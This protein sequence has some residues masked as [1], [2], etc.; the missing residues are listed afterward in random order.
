MMAMDHMTSNVR[1]ESGKPMIVANCSGFF[2]D[3]LS[4]AREMVEGGPIDILTGDYLAELTMLILWKSKESGRGRG[5]VH[6]FLKQMEEVLG[7]CLDRGIRVVANA[8][9]LNPAG[10]AE[11]LRSL[12]GRLGLAPQIA[13]VEGDDLLARLPELLDE[14]HELRHMDTGQLLSEL[15]AN[16]ITANA[17]LGAWGIADALEGGADIVVCPRVTDASLVVGPAAWWFGWA[18]DDW[19]QLA[20]AVAAGHVIECGAQATGGNYAF[21]GSI[22][23]MLEPGFPLAEVHS[24]GS[25]V[26]TK[27]P[28]TGGEV[29]IGTV[30]AQLL[31]ETSGTHYSNP[32]VVADFGTV[33]LTEVGVNRVLL[34]GTRGFPA[35]PDLKVC[36]NYLAGYRNSATFVMTGLDIEAK[37]DLLQR[38]LFQRLGGRDRFTKVDVRMVGRPVVNA[39]TSDEAVCLLQ[40]TVFDNDESKVGRAFAGAAIEL[41]LSSYPGFFMTAPPSS[42]TTTGVYWPALLPANAVRHEVVH[43]DGRRTVPVE[44]SRSGVVLENADNEE[45]PLAANVSTSDPSIRVPLGQLVGARSGDKGGNANVGLWCTSMEAYAWLVCELSVDRFRLLLPEAEQCPVERHL[46][47][48]IAAMNFVIVG[49]LDEG[50]AATARFDAQAKGLGEFLRSRLVEVPQHLLERHP[51]SIPVG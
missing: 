49:L 28:E 25:A 6:T 1:R 20:G 46:F 9:G 31:Y 50:V 22:P 27:H 15:D 51:S 48:N 32:D 40:I 39:D 26:I 35:P 21:F 11:D 2:G 24:D 43:H 16:V 14:G 12:A 23:D 37:A 45:P 38:G 19:D 10:L 36:L 33:R 30:T 8:G 13:H 47:P 42:A 4:A 17:Y 18:H 3:R 7:T 29:S 34:E 41:G 5:Y 44:P